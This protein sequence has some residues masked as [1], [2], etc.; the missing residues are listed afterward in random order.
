MK[1]PP[2]TLSIRLRRSVELN[3]PVTEGGNCRP[4][5]CP[6]RFPTRKRTGFTFIELLI[7]LAIMVTAFTLIFTIFSGAV[8]AWRRGTET[9]TKLH[10]GDFVMEQLVQS[11][12]SMAFFTSVPEFYEFRLEKGNAGGNPADRLSWVT[13]SAALMPLDSEFSEGLKRVSVGIE[14]TPRHGYGVE[15]RGMPHLAEEE[16]AEYE[17]WFISTRVRGLRCRVY[18]D[19]DG[20]WMERWEETNSIPSLIEI[21]LFVEEDGDRYAPPLQMRRAVTIPIAPAVTNRVDFSEE[22]L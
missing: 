18:D 14:R 21:T 6:R 15:V 17:S 3:P 9:M 16:D 10:H 1:V 2:E 19:E 7:A 8:S 13:S 20:R 5:L 12:R 22:A 11:L 4:G